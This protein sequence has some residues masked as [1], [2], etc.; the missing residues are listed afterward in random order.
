MWRALLL[1]IG[2]M[3]AHHPIVPWSQSQDKLGLERSR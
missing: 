2:W 1:P 3:T